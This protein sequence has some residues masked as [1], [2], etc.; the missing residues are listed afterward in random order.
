MQTHIVLTSCYLLGLFFIANPL[1]VMRM[2]M[3]F[4]PNHFVK[5]VAHITGNRTK[6]VSIMKAQPW[7]FTCNDDGISRQKSDRKIHYLELI[8][9]ILR[10]YLFIHLAIGEKTYWF[11]SAEAL[12]NHSNGSESDFLTKVEVR[13]RA[14]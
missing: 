12:H 6:I 3:L 5:L 4:F 2:V 8:V 14:N 1:F 11:I 10:M 7:Y 13:I 9:Y